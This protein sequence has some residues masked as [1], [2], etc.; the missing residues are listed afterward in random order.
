[1]LGIAV[2][3][4]SLALTLSAMADKIHF[5]DGR[6]LEGKIIREGESFVEFRIKVGSIEQTK[7]IDRSEISKIERDDPT[8]K[9]EENLAKDAAAK[10]DAKKA[11]ANKHTGATRVAIL[12]FGP[13][14]DWQGKTQ[15]MVGVQ[16]SSKAFK[17]VIPMLEKAKADVVVIRINSG[18]GYTM[19]MRRFQE[20]F[21]NN[22]KPRFRTVAWVESAISA[23]A[24]SP[25]VLEEFYFLPNGNIGG[26]TE[27]SGGMI[28]SKGGQ[29]EM[30]LAHM[31]KASRLGKRDPII[32]RAMQIQEPLSYD[33]DESGNVVWRQDELGAHVLNR[34]SHVYTMNAQDAV[35]SHFG[36]GIAAT[37]EELAKVMGLQ[38]VEWVALDASEFIDNNIR[39]NDRVEKEN[40]VVLQKYQL[41]I[42]VASQL[43]DKK[44][45]GAELAR[46]KRYLAEL[47]TMV[48]VNP[49]FEFHL[50]IPPEW[51]VEQDE[52]IK[53]IS[54]RP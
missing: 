39:E 1:M 25:W 21:E 11:D 34:S 17:D 3:G 48:K 10:A 15:D 45:R 29:L 26:C 18:G 41:A 54:S 22:Y 8:P 24:M 52:I 7:Y 42:G 53:E 2:V 16:I 5:K 23:A 9:T 27:W 49:N 30:V 13:P 31:E 6:V 28:A 20:I 33:I 38:E 4:A 50:Q 37:K 32:M 51:F 35:R 43:Q 47:R 40:K 14:S 12:N 19:E 36:K 44:Q 46:A